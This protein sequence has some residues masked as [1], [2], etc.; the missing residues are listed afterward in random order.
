MRNIFYILIFL[1]ASQSV[2]AQKNCCPEFKLVS[3]M[4]PCREQK[5]S[6][7]N[8]GHDNPH[9]KYD[10]Q[11]CKHTTQ[12]YYIFPQKP[13]FTFTWQ[14]T[15]GT[16]ASTIGNPMN[17][18]WGSGTDGTIKVFIASNDGLCKDT[19]VNTVQLTD[20]PIAAFSFSP[21]S[22]VCLNQNIAFN[23][24]SIGATSYYWDFG[25][26]VTTTQTNPSHSYTSPGTY[27][28]MLVAY[29]Q[30]VSGQDNPAGQMEK[31]DCGCRDTIRQTITVKNEAALTIEPGCKQM[32]CLGDTATYCTPNE[33]TSYNWSVTGGTI[34]GANNGRC[35]KVV[36]NG[37]FPATVTLNGACGG[38]CGNTT[39]IN[40][41]V[42]YPTMTPDGSVK[43]C[44]NTVT[45][46]TLPTMP[47][48][49]YNWTVTGP[50]T[51]I[52]YS[53]NTPTIDIQWG[54][55][56][57]TYTIQCDYNNPNTGCGGKATLNVEVLQPFK[58]AGQQKYCVGKPF[59]FT[60]NG[61]A[62]WAINPTTGFT[63]ATFSAGTSISG[64]WTTPGTYTIHATT[65]NPAL[66]CNNTDSLQVEVFDKPTVAPI[67]G[68]NLICPGNNSMYQAASNMDDGLFTW[69]V[70]G[71]YITAYMG[72]NY[73]SVMIQWN[74][75]GPYKVEVFQ[76]VNGCSSS[77][78]SMVLNAYT[79]PTITGNNTSCMDNILT[80]TTTSPAP[81]GG[82]NWTLS[83][84]LG[85]IINGQGTNSVD[86]L[87]HGSTIGNTCVL[88]LTTCGGSDTK[89]IT[90]YNPP[91]VTITKAGSLCSTTGITLTASVSGAGSYTWSLNS[92]VLGPPQNTQTI[93]ITQAGTYQV[94]IIDA[95][96]CKIKGGL[97][98]PE[99][100]L[101]L[102]ATISTQDKTIWGC[103]E[104]INTTLHAAPSSSLYCYQWYKSLVPSGVGSAIF[105]ATTSNYTAT[106]PGYYWCKIYLCNT[107]CDEYTDTIRV[108][109]IPCD[110]CT[111][112]TNYIPSFTN[113]SC[114]PISFAAVT[115]P[116]AALGT[117][118]WIFGDGDEGWGTSITHQFRDTGIYKVCA[119]FSNPPAWCP[120]EICKDIDI[121]IATNFSATANCDKVTL[122]N[123][124]KSRNPILSYNWSFPGGSPA[125]S[126][127]ATPPVI[128]YSSGGLHY[129]TLT[130]TDGTCTVS[131]TDTIRTYNATATMSV[132]TP[133]CAKTDA[134]FTATSS[135]PGLIYSWNFG[136]GFVS[137]LQN[138]NHAYQLPG[139]YIVTLTVSNINGCT[140]TYTQNVTVNPQPTVTITGSQH[141][142]PGATTTLT[143]PSGFTTYQWYKDGIVISGATAS[144]LA[145]SSVGQYWVVAANGPGCAAESNHITITYLSS[146]IAKIKGSKIA[147][148]NNLPFNLQNSVWSSNYQYQWSITGPA[149][150]SFSPPT[151]YS[152][153]VSIPSAT[154]GNYEVS[155]IVTDNTTGCKSYDTIC[156]FVEQSPTVTINAPTGTLCEG[157]KYTFTANATPSIAPQQYIFK[158]TNGF[159]GNPLVT[160]KPGLIGVTV[161]NPNGCVA[162]AYAGMI[163]P[164]PNVSLFPVGCDTLCITDTL[165]FPLPMPNPLGYD[166]T[167][168]DDDGTAVAN[169]GTGVVFPL[170]NLQPGIHHLYATVAFPG[171]CADTTGKF[172]LYVKDCS[173]QPPCDNCTNLLD[174]TGVSPVSITIGTNATIVNYNLTFTIQKPV[175]E[176]RISLA[177]LKYSWKDST[178]MNCKVQVLERGCLFPGTGSTNIGSLT[179]DDYT[180]SGATPSNVNHCPEE[181]IWKGS[182]LLQPGTYTVPIQVTLAKPLTKNCVLKLE[183]VC[184]HLTLI[185]SL[186][187][188][189]EKIICASGNIPNSDDCKCNLTDTWTNLYL[190]PQQPGLPHPHNQI[191]CNT[192]L[193]GIAAN[194]N[195]VLSGVYYCQ[196]K[197]ISSKNE[198]VVYNQQNQIIYTKMVTS[199]N[200]VISFLTAGAYTITLTANCGNKKCAC[201]FKVNVGDVIIPPGG[202]GGGGG[203]P[204]GEPTGPI[205]IPLPPDLPIK[206][207]SI[208]N[209]TLPPDFNGGVLV[210]KNDSTLFEKYYSRKHKVD[211]HTAF[212]IASITKT[213]TSAS[214]LKLMEDGKLNIEEPVAKYL[215]QLPYKDITIKMLLTHRSGLEDYLNF[216]DKVGWDRSLNVT[217]KNLLDIIVDN[218]SK[219]LIHK[220]GE[221]YDYSNTN[222]ALLALIIEAVSGS[223]YSNFL[224]TRF[225]MPL[226]MDDTYVVNI[227][228]FAKATKSYYRNG[229]TY[230]LRYLDLI[231][232]DKCV[233]ST[234]NDLKKWDNALRTG[235]VLKK[236]TL[237]LAYKTIGAGVAFNST[238]TVGWKKVT[239]T[240]GKQVLYHDGWWGGNRALLIRLVDENVVIAVLSNNNFTKIK[241]IKKLCD[242][243]GDYKMSTNKVLNF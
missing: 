187:K 184:F 23:N 180:S 102:S 81:P 1:F 194:V 83:N 209:A 19:I 10:L 98:V 41:P 161:I 63:P 179:W 57:G 183:K 225:F 91:P 108:D 70:T 203:Y 151:G 216:I 130:I 120:K 229:S 221:V 93:T 232:G 78:V 68:S 202:G 17:I 89:T 205:G 69:T 72:S 94:E 11:A 39:T 228:N 43:V 8:G 143:A 48:T 133:L 186:C 204:P 67:V 73:D 141:I 198:I 174:S 237:E 125:T 80:Y 20:A 110:P 40:V 53:K 189:C 44:P 54:N 29:N 118:H 163:K 85:T 145:V 4:Q 33:C 71:G 177:D 25:D 62:T 137:N 7:T 227:D 167:W 112:S 58:I 113:T 18:L 158:W 65:T 199:L 64:T 190:I 162:T 166:V 50:N 195:Y 239:T 168:Y 88:T 188:S 178:C 13:G 34:L 96:G 214:I 236:A 212:D 32:L 154:P 126:S 235:N 15:G 217:N 152:T 173:L 27:T 144:S 51:I 175:K 230:N 146:P 185:D 148:T 87:W 138:V 127:L 164:R 153:S 92:V 176:V 14:V 9:E 60:A 104:T 181:L 3:D 171:G 201:T 224:S 59:S 150:G 149:A 134:P 117:V 31:M 26:G 103:T 159:V 197:C 97:V 119:Y 142:C 28:I 6:P 196:G 46:Y 182:G 215:P 207:D 22:P 223:S 211:S 45:N 121:N 169:V 192:V 200:E 129:V 122:V 243:F 213:F 234:P 220:P 16:P 101:N 193:T 74:N 52:G 49:F 116:S 107:S 95:N 86:I 160:G 21:L 38:T 2:L 170:S 206:I 191:L 114:N 56:T 218:K 100:K 79:A 55:A 123:L 240:T 84:A 30:P 66:F 76:T 47:G 136:D 210:A 35:I 61:S 105:G 75:A 219:I 12:S 233:Y 222:Y 208:I 124:S 147:C 156:V 109:K 172:D 157:Q 5:E 90:V 128:T 231:Y 36:W 242:L 241:D 77:P 131:Y 37:S 99:E 155:L 111:G 238:Y 226:Q 106:S 115:T 42:L 24:T 135:T 132:P 165:R 82:Y 140:N 139:P